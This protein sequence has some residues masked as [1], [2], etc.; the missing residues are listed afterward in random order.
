MQL[1]LGRSEAKNRKKYVERTLMCHGQIYKPDKYSLTTSFMYTC[2]FVVSYT[3]IDVLN[4]PMEVYGG[5]VWF[6]RPG[7]I[8]SR[9]CYF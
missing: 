7:Y 5:T 4:L 9:K 2:R 6:Y 1:W 8:I 3:V